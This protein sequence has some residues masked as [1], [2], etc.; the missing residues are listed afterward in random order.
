[1]LGFKVTNGGGLYQVA[2]WPKDKSIQDTD[3]LTKA[4]A[5][6]SPPMSER[7]LAGFLLNQG[8]TVAAVGPA[9][10]VTLAFLAAVAAEQLETVPGEERPIEDEGTWGVTTVTCYPSTYTAVK[11]VNHEFFLDT[12]IPEAPR[13]GE[14]NCYYEVKCN[15][16][17]EDTHDEPVM[18]GAL[19]QKK[20]FSLEGECPKTQSVNGECPKQKEYTITKV[21]PHVL[22]NFNV[23]CEPTTHYEAE[24]S[25]CRTF[26]LGDDLPTEKKVKCKTYP[27]GKGPPKKA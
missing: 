15:C 27:P 10:P 13:T 22:F 9:I 3:T 23:L 19:C 4:P 14:L 20:D 21:F 26:C 5:W 12:P 6:V 1:V 2:V 7:A 18:N 24:L 8:V 17:G 11:F 25:A 16:C